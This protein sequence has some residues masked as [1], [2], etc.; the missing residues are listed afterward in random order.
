MP[1]QVRGARD[2][3]NKA[4]RSQDS[5]TGRRV[6]GSDRKAQ[7]TR[8]TLRL[9]AEHG[10]QG[11]SMSRISAAVGVSSA[12]LYRH[13]ESRDDILIAAFDT[14]MDRFALWL[15]SSYDP[16]AL[17]RLRDMCRRHASLFSQD[18]E[19]WNAPM[20]QFTVYIPKDRVREHVHARRTKMFEAVGQ[21]IDEGRA[22]GCIAPDVDVRQAVADLYAW[23]YW[24]DLSYLEGLDHEFT[25]RNSADM[26]GRILKRISVPLD[27]GGENAGT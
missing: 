3:A 20:F 27:G 13:F 21:I 16:C 2:R 1:T 9:V 12:A 14:L 17:H 25:Q 15:E 5:L 23:I 11:T 4:T 22:Q 8:E 18:V 6:R 19:G 10:I 7:I 24:E 26:Y